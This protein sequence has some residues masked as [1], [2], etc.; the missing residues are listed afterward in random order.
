MLLLSIRDHFSIAG[1]EGTK[2]FHSEIRR[3]ISS[4]KR[5]TKEGVVGI[6]IF[7]CIIVDNFLL[8]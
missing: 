4:E 8:H 7:V 2:T 5:T 1:N 3:A 6:F